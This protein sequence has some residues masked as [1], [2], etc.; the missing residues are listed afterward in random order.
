MSVAGLPF[1]Q[2]SALLLW[3]AAFVLS[4]RTWLR[5]RGDD[6]GD[7]L[8]AGLVWL[9]VRA[10]L[11]TL[12]L[13]A[14]APPGD[15]WLTTAL[16]LLGFLLVAW[17]FLSPPLSPR[18]ADRLFG[19]G[20]L[21]A[22]LVCFLVP[23]QWAR[24]FFYGLPPFPHPALT[25]AH[26][27]LLL[28]ALTAL[29]R[30]E[31]PEP[32]PREW[33]LTIAAASLAGVVG[34]LLP[35]PLTPP[36]TSAL[37]AGSGLFTAFWLD[38]LERRPRRETARSAAGGCDD[39]SIA[40]LLDAG[41]ALSTAAGFPD[42][43]KMAAPL[44][45]ESIPVWEVAL[46]L[47]AGQ[48]DGPST[49]Q[50]V[51]RW[52][53]PPE[54]EAATEPFPAASAPV[55]ADALNAPQGLAVTRE[56]DGERLRSLRRF[57]AG[58]AQAVLLL[59]LPASDGPPQG[60]VLVAHGDGPLD[61]GRR[62][63]ARLWA[64]QVGGAVRC[65]RLRDDLRHRSRRLARVLR[66]HEQ[67]T[68]QLHAILESIAD[69]VVVSDAHD[70][71]IL[72]NSAA[73]DILQTT[74]EEVV[75][76]P[77]GQILGRM[78]PT[79]EVGLIGTLTETSPYGTAAIFQVAERVV[80]M[81]MAPVENTAG[82]QLGVVAV[83]R[84]ITALAQAEAER[85]R[86]LADLREHS[87]QLEEAAEQ[88]REMDRLKSQF[89]ANMSH[90]LRTPLN[91]IIGFAGVMLKEID[92]PL[93]DM[94][95]EDLESIQKSGKHLLSLITDILDISRLWAGKLSLDLG[96]VSIPKVVD[97]AVEMAAP[98]IGD[99]PLTLRRLVA[100]DLPPVRADEKRVRQVLINLLSNAI[101][102]TD[103]GE[104]T[105]S[106]YRQ[107]G[108]VI[109]N[110]SD[111]GIGIPPEYQE[112]IFEEFRRVDDSRTRKVD[113]LGLGLSIS[114]RLVELHGGE[115]GV[116]SRPGEGSRF[117]FSLPIDGPQQ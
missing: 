42:L 51:A 78:V 89:I 103:A 76:Y 117:Y 63:L 75:G 79:G 38:R 25:W 111:T 49:L 16:D 90:E 60:V 87:R 15:G 84:D 5:R 70:Q 54:N 116:E 46:F 82:L 102:Y 61:R 105:V 72:V 41:A 28:A 94:Q 69:G 56:A 92:G 43:L 50:L 113:G 44:L 3:A 97:D 35:L 68:G 86:L 32:P 27:A 34:L 13:P 17:P 109:I 9:L 10:A 64:G 2:G 12:G 59:P 36:Q 19:L 98:L 74:P 53:H 110:V 114:R 14:A 26:G 37:A 21:A 80:Q 11:L 48:P 88:L 91:S 47:A 22:A 71:V 95:R 4:H 55:L 83:M 93:T 77:F 81:S 57:L 65:V 8:V 85:E 96:E 33:L 66:Q 112:A 67:E 20:L 101:K 39:E 115:M 7:L 45:N 99:K 23:W 108:R 106:T 58:R 40:R 30:P 100:P 73:C 29:D 107:D 18:L 31:R 24:V 104:V 6:A 1:A 52:P 62:R